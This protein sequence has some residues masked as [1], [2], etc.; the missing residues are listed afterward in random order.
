MNWSF[1]GANDPE[2]LPGVNF[3]KVLHTRFLYKILAPKITNPKHSFLIFGIKI[4]YEKC[5]HKMLIKLAPCLLRSTFDYF[6]SLDLQISELFGCTEA[7]GPISTNLHG[8]VSQYTIHMCAD[9]KELVIFHSYFDMFLEMWMHIRI[10][11]RQ[12]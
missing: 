2:G 1:A 5:S 3:I 4:S 10:A 7:T 11:F 9:V 6:E 12:F 8:K